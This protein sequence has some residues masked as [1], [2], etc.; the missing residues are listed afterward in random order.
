[1]KLRRVLPVMMSHMKISIVHAL[2]GKEHY[3]VNTIK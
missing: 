1:M 3:S 2:S